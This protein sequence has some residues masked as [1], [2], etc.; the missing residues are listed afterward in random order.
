M[1]ENATQCN[2]SNMSRTEQDISCGYFIKRGKEGKIGI[3]YAVRIA[4]AVK[5]GMEYVMET[6]EQ[7][8]TRIKKKMFL[9]YW[10]KS[11]GVVSICCDKIEIDRATYYRWREDDPVFREALVQVENNRNKD[12]EDV[13]MGKILVEK[14]A[15]CTKFYLSRKHPDYKEKIVNEVFAGERTL[16]DLIDEANQE[17]DRKPTT[18]RGADKDPQ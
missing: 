10:E 16:E 12:V 1:S 13:L 5:M 11:R 6:Q 9:D 14:D 4:G 7:A 8:R 3:S 15:G 2:S 17:D 18:D